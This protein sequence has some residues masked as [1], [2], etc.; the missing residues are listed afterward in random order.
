MV[1]VSDFFCG[2]GGSSTGAVAAGAEVRVAVNHW[3]RAIETHNTNHPNTD[4]YLDDIQATHPSRYPK[5]D[6]LWM[7]PECFAAGTLILTEQG[8]VAIEDVRVGDLVLTHRGRWM[9]VVST[10][11]RVKDTIIVS[12]QGHYGIETTADHPFYARQ[13]TRQWDNAKRDYDRRVYSDPTW[14]NAATLT[15]SKWRWATPVMYGHLEIPKVPGRGFAFSPDLF[16]MVGRWL[17]DGS[18]R[19]R[20]THSEITICCG[21]HEV[22]LL[23][24]R[25]ERFMPQH[26]ERAQES[27]LRWRCREIRTSYLFETAHSGLVSW[28]LE[29]FG[30]HANGKRI[31]AWA[32][33]MP[34]AWRDS[35]LDGY[36]SADGHRNHRRTRADSIS[37]RLI[38]GM[39]LLAESLGCR[40]SFGLYTHPAGQIEGREYP[41][42]DMWMTA[43]ENNASQRTAFSDDLHSWSLVKKVVP[44]RKNVTVYN[45]SVA[46]D[47]SYVAEGIVVHNCTNHS[48]AKGKSRKGIQQLDLWGENR[49][50]PEEERSRATM[51][52]VVEHAEY[53]RHPII[54]VENVVDIRHWQHYE[55]WLQDMV[56]LGYNYKTLYLN[57]QFFGVPQSRDR[58]YSVFWLK[59]NHAPDLDFRPAAYCPK[60]ERVVNSTQAWKKPEFQ[61]GRYGA[62]RQYVYKCPTCATQVQPGTIPAAAIIDWSLPAELIG[63]RANPLKPKTLDR[64]RA[65]IRKFARPVIIETSMTHAGSIGK[66]KSADEPL[67]TQ[68]TRQS[69][70]VAV[71]PFLLSYMNNA[72][73]PRSVDDPMYTVATTHTPPVIVPPHIVPLRGTAVP[74]ST[75]EPLTT[76]IASAQQHA[77]I[78]PPWIFETGGTWERA[79]RSVEQPMPTQLTRESMSLFIPP[80]LMSYYSRDDAQ[81]S[82]DKSLP[83]ITAERRHSLIIPPFMAM[84]RNHQDVTD[85]GEPMNTIV[86]SAPHHALVAPPFLASY[87]GNGENNQRVDEPMNTVTTKDRHALVIPELS[88]ADVDEIMMA[89]RFRMLSPEELKLGMSFP[90]EY[91]ILGNQREQVRQVGN[92]VAC[93]VA[94][95]IIQR[96]ME[97]LS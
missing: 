82:L 12:G 76:I 51:R 38:L 39:R 81:S 78:V 55:D 47:E 29:N 28:L 77:L 63:A 93:N 91:I 85:L 80:Y 37:K 2:A 23:R 4:H 97:S 54:I 41:P 3:D 43:W 20:E 94:A 5:T 34:R 72:T 21:K 8:L 36:L 64:I 46:A 71:P 92:A 48:L 59:G 62:N 89:S 57:A 11:R 35:L 84:L 49:V 79:P 32:L 10:M 74:K 30:Q 27:E 9:P 44:G 13:Q 83:T 69:F 96:C 19:I 58:W 95:W 1:T 68:T 7:S 14:V 87:Y 18:L 17:G 90:A 75:D 40:A 67:A 26:D 15:E 52:E 33:T 70:G 56:N 31:P 24:E 42:Y 6:I 66:F 86:A 50:N 22:D 60:C 45:L 25:L 88:A 53:H 65:G 61:W 16:W 73:P